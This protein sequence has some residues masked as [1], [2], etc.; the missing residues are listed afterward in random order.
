MLG[1][2]LGMT[3]SGC[4]MVRDRTACRASPT[5]SGISLIWRKDFAVRFTREIFATANA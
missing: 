3:L 2:A 1:F 4:G 5:A